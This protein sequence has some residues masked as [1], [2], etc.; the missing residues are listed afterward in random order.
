[1]WEGESPHTERLSADLFDGFSYRIP[2]SLRC[3][4][5]TGFID[6]QGRTQCKCSVLKITKFKPESPTQSYCLAEG[7][8]LIH[9][10]GA[11]IRQEV[12]AYG[13]LDGGKNPIKLARILIN[14]RVF[15]P[16]GVQPHS[17][18]VAD[19]KLTIN[20]LTVDKLDGV[21]ILD[22]VLSDSEKSL[23]A[24]FDKDKKQFLLTTTGEGGLKS[25]GELFAQFHIKYE[26]IESQ[27]WARIPYGPRNPLRVVPSTVLLQ[28]T[29]DNDQLMEGRLVILGR[30][31]GD[32]NSSQYRIERM[33]ANGNWVEL[34]AKIRIETPGAGK[35]I[36]KLL[37][38]GRY[39]QNDSGTRVRL[40]LC[41]LESDNRTTEFNVSI[42][43]KD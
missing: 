25:P 14:A 12:E 11:D 32:P 36:G 24:T 5:E 29:K 7:E 6:I 23:A 22:A 28:R 3:A 42:E 40:R 19:G 33:D 16:V 8:I 1:M 39:F 4:K 13:I 43:T 41:E 31:S 15:P 27:T 20:T 30:N 21:E 26:G 37:V 18:V 2:F 35:S 10:T 38:E 17:I 9:A 34:D